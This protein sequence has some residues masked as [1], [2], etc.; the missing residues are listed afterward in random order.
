MQSILS[1]KMPAQV[2]AALN[3]LAAQSS[4]AQSVLAATSAQEVIANAVASAAN[5]PIK[6]G[7]KFPLLILFILHTT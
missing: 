2:L 4:L 7:E 5:N 6:K 1:L 3:Q